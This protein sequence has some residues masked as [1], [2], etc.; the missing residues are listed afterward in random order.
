MVQEMSN[1]GL[2]IGSHGYNHFNMLKLRKDEAQD[3]FIM[4]RRIIEQKI[5]KP[6]TNFS[7]PYGKFNQDLVNLALDCKYLHCFISNH[8]VIDTYENIIPRN[9]INS[10]MNKDKINRLLFVS[11]KTLVMWKIE[12]LGKKIIKILFGD[13]LYK[14]IRSFMFNLKRIENIK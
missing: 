8:G 2:L 6:V 14:K 13:N 9:S 5:G 12:D 11:K 10:K 4:S 1:S 7:F 3:E